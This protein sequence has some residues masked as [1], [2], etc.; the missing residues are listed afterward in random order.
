VLATDFD[1][2]LRLLAIGYS[3]LG[4]GNWDEPPQKI[5]E[6]WAD[7][8]KPDFRYWVR[9][10]LQDLNI[11]KTGADI[12]SAAALAYPDFTGWCDEVAQGT[13]SAETAKAVPP[14][15]T[16]RDHASAVPADTDLWTLMV[17]AI[18]QR[19]DAPAVSALIEAV[20]ARSLK[21]GTANDR[22]TYT[23]AKTLGMKIG[24]NYNP[25]NRAYW[26]MRKEGRIYITYVTQIT[27]KPPYA[28]PLPYG[29]S[30]ATTEEE[31]AAIR[32]P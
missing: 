4:V 15:K 31:Q 17:T 2:F 10:Q 32:F 5:D 18:G 6:N 25:K 7:N 1:Q 16:Q 23:T 20:D 24:A 21:P 13:L 12:V 8:I 9:I 26:P 11:P 14:P 3:E 29:L 28:G 22:S 19:I 30:W 27:L